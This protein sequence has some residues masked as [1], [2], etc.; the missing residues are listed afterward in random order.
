M[1]NKTGGMLAAKMGIKG[2]AYNVPGRT[3]FAVKAGSA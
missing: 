3:G 2:V 1:P